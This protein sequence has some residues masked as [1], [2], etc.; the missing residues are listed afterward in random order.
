MKS[1][2]SMKNIAHL[3]FFLLLYGCGKSTTTTLYEDAEEG[4]SSDWYVVKGEDSPAIISS[5]NDSQYCV[6]LPVNWYK[7]SDKI[8]RNPHE[9]H[10]KLN[11]EKEKVLT[12]DVGGTGMEVPHYV[13][14]VKIRTNYGERTL[15][16]DSFYNHE[17]L[18]AKKTTHDKG[19][20]TMIFP[21][22]TELVRGWGYADTSLWA[23]FKVDIEAYLHLF[24][25]DNEIEWVDTFIAT[26]GNLDN[27]RLSSQ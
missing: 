19:S 18:S 22:P 1:I 25:P 3:L 4:L 20:A 13:L 21:S 6:N 12:V 17:G 8:W 11:N 2:F 16:W 5:H 26:G 9:Y 14:G 27:I 15:L 24:E 7:V 10:L 23:Q